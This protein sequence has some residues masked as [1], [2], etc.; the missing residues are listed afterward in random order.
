[1]QVEELLCKK[2]NI[3]NKGYFC[4]KNL[5]FTLIYA[6]QTLVAIPLHIPHEVAWPKFFFPS[7]GIPTVDNI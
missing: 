7:P 1:M 3:N 6:L 2:Q 4:P 5:W